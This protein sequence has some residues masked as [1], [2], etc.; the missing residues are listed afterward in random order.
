[1]E[2]PSFI[3]MV[4][5]LPAAAV[6]AG[7][8]KEKPVEEEE[9]MLLFLFPAASAPMENAPGLGARAVVDPRYLAW[10][11]ACCHKTTSLKKHRDLSPGSFRMPKTLP[12]TAHMQLPHDTLLSFHIFSKLIE[13]LLQHSN[14]Q[15]Q[16]AALPTIHH[17]RLAIDSE[18]W[19]CGTSKDNR[20]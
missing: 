16:G 20:F 9:V 17:T 13:L 1:M 15:E 7:A 5:L 10:Y 8:P 2:N 19:W 3:V 18:P 6:A 14:D 12:C 4:L 11:L